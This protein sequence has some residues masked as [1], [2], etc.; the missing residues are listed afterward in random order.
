M[1]RTTTWL[2]AATVLSLGASLLM[3]HIGSRLLNH[4]YLVRLGKIA[5]QRKLRALERIW[6][7]TRVRPALREGNIGLVTIILSTLI[8]LKSVAS[9]VL[10]CVMVFWLPFAS[11]IVP[12]IVYE[13]DPDDPSLLAWIRKVAA[14]QLTSHVLAAAVGFAAIVAGPLAGV[15]LA[16]TLESNM[17]P[18]TVLCAVSLTFAVAAGKAEATG[19]ARRGI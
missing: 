12:A 4:R 5:H 6:P 8:L 19:L 1:T 18:F 7:L 14:L 9:L 15:P 2:L 13:H 10:G 11:L 16:A 3:L 17:V